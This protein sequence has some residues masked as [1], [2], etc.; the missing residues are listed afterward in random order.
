M[1]HP[2]SEALQRDV[3]ECCLRTPEKLGAGEV[4]RGLRKVRRHELVDTR[5]LAALFDL[6]VRAGL[7]GLLALGSY[8][9][10]Y[11]PLK[12]RSGFSVLVGAIPGAI[13][14]M[15]GYVA[16]TGRFGI[17]PGTLFAVQFMWQ[18]PHFWAIAWVA[19]EDYLKAGYKMLP[20]KEGRTAASARQILLYTMLCIPASLLPWA[21]PG[22]APMVGDIAFTVAVLTGLGFLVPAVRLWRSLDVKDARQLMFASFLYLPIVQLTYV[23]DK[24]P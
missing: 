12:S 20:F 6:G 22:E 21:L 4:D 10:A 19:H 18:F 24:I 15:L 11:T 17:E 23:L 13:P 3:M 16:A 1:L 5:G 2:R 9:L 8:V 7:L 14:P